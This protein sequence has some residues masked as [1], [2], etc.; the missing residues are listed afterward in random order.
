M[1]GFNRPL[2]GMI[3]PR[4]DGNNDPLIRRPMAGIIGT[5]PSN[6]PN[7][8]PSKLPP[9]SGMISSPRRDTFSPSNEPETNKKGT[10]KK[11]I[12]GALGIT[13]LVAL[14]SKFIKK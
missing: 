8:L 10:I 11:V 2:A 6:R 1:T 5:P 13:A 12:L 9:M 4:R 7:N 14:G 3:S